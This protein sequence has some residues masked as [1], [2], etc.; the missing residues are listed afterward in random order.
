VGGGDGTG[1]KNARP[2]SHLKPALPPFLLPDR[3]R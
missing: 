3:D 1:Q 2:H